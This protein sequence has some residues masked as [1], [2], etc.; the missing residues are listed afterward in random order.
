MNDNANS[1]TV[2]DLQQAAEK[3]KTTPVRVCGVTFPHVVHPDSK[4]GTWG[5]CASCF[6]PVLTPEGF[7]ARFG[8]NP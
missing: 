4:D 6:A 7:E 3:I 5:T 1:L 2:E 8:G